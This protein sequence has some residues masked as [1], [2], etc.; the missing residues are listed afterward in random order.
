MITFRIFNITIGSCFSKACSNEK[1]FW[2]RY[3]IIAQQHVHNWFK[4]LTSAPTE[5][6]F[7]NIKTATKSFKA[8]IANA[9]LRA[10]RDFQKKNNVTPTK[11]RKRE[12]RGIEEHE[13]GTGRSKRV[14]PDG[15]SDFKNKNATTFE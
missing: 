10:V 7:K 13:Q 2:Q 15:F 3:G 8:W 6:V 11:K 4:N 1:D 14:Y 9:L 12:G 5:R